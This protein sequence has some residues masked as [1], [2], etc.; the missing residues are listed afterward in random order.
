MFAKR[1]A[2]LATIKIS[3][4]WINISAISWLIVSVFLLFITLKPYNKSF[5]NIDSK[6]YRYADYTTDTLAYTVDYNGIVD[7]VARGNHKAIFAITANVD[8]DFRLRSKTKFEGQ[9]ARIYLWRNEIFEDSFDVDY[10]SK[11]TYC[12]D[13]KKD[14]NIRIWTKSL[15][16][17]AEV[18]FKL[19][20]VT[21]FYQLSLYAIIFI[22]VAVALWFVFALKVRHILL[23]SVIF[24]LGILNE[25]LYL[26]DHG[27]VGMLGI[28]LTSLFLALSSYMSSF[29]SSNIWRNV[30]QSLIGY[31]SMAG[32]AFCSIFSFNYWRFGYKMDFEAIVSVLQ[33]NS[34]EMVEFVSREL[35]IWAILAGL[36]IIGI[37]LLNWFFFSYKNNRT[38]S[39]SFVIMACVIG[40]SGILLLFQS[41][42]LNE[43]YTARCR[44]YHEIAKFNQVQNSFAQNKKLEA[45]K[46]KKGETYIVVIGESQCKE[47]LSLYGYHKKTSPFLDSMKANNQL[48][49][50]QNA[51]SCHTH[52]IM[53]LQQA[54]TQANQYNGL[55][56]TQ[57]PTLISV[58]NS[59]D[60]ETVWLSNQVKLSNWDNVVS[61]IAEGCQKKYFINKNIGE[62]VSNSPYD[63]NLIPELKEILA[64]KTEKNRVVFVHLMGNHANY[65][66]RYPTETFA[67]IRSRARADYG[68]N[69]NLEDWM[70]YDNSM[71]YNDWVMRQIIG[72]VS[73]DKE[74]TSALFYMSDHG[75]DLE[76]KRGH[77]VGQF[78]FRMTQI[79]MYFWFSDRYNTAYPDKVNQLIK[80]VNKPVSNDVV[81][82]TLL[83]MF[84]VKT[85]YYQSKYDLFSNSF[86]IDT[87][88]TK[89]GR[90]PYMDVENE[91]YWTQKNVDSLR[92]NQL[93]QKIGSHRTNTFGKC[94]EVLKSGLKFIEID[95]LMSD[96]LMVGHGEKKAMPGI[97]LEQYLLEINP[98]KLD[99][100]W[101]D[102]KN[103]NSSNKDQILLELIKL[104][105]RF[106]LKSKLIF[107]T[108]ATSSFVSEFVQSGF[109]VS[110][111]LPT[112]IA[113]KT[114]PEQQK[115]AVSILAQLK[116]QHI[117]AI[118]FDVWLYPFVKKY[119]EPKLPK[120]IVYHTWDLELQVRNGL[121]Y[122]QLLNKP[123]LYDPRVK[124][125][126]VGFK[127]VFDL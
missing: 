8:F 90:L 96:K 16:E 50:M 32:I 22:W 17:Q 102:V 107:E 88:K 113:S 119:M 36:V 38:W 99:K 25:H 76:E 33:S 28:L 45:S 34:T 26:T 108:T 61:A 123:Y 13:I 95:V 120:N 59:A 2:N 111:Y 10:A 86:F 57:V 106:K 75:D 20:R 68:K 39:N 51:F 104:D 83:S 121:F 118:S 122:S 112:D 116:N 46:E 37:P 72:L 60:F 29:I 79:P 5:K 64:D 21:L 71:K 30:M 101:L 91:F 81:F 67:G 3:K 12:F 125:I 109:H 69:E 24:L 58:L 82:E 126:L 114:Q 84:D 89:H 115:A 54:L 70:H 85:P 48:V 87:L 117:S 103:L 73:S 52:T 124:S 27:Y 62:T 31:I 4:K 78:T 127:S 42:F 105:A 53:V 15:T 1:L 66:E 41:Q 94:N 56:Y 14:E 110:Y 18:G 55:D 49:V 44:Y 19:E 47:H 74:S 63:E 80:N 23:P 100:I 77:N 98:Y 93:L 65:D 11:K 92:A 40:V 35:H 43:F 7:A 97:S 9:K 6:T